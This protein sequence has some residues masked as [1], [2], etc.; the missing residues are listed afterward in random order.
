MRTSAARASGP[1]TQKTG[2]AT[3]PVFT[4]FIT[5]DDNIYSLQIPRPQPGP[6][7]LKHWLR[8]SDRA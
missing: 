6:I 2:A 3:A 4:N 8:E 5:H 7:I 1:E